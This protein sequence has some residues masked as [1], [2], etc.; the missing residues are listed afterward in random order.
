[1]L[2]VLAHHTQTKLAIWPENSGGGE[3]ETDSN[4]QVLKQANSDPHNCFSNIHKKVTFK[5]SNCLL[6]CSAFSALL[7]LQDQHTPCVLWNQLLPEYRPVN[8][9]NYSL[10][11]F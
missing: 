2:K 1:M 3:T 7:C 8:Q 5:P 10:L 9:V 4:N 6:L 11:T